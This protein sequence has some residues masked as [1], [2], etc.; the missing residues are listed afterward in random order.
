MTHPIYHAVIMCRHGN[1]VI[2]FGVLSFSSERET[3]RQKEP[4]E[5]KRTTRI[6][7]RI[8]QGEGIR[9]SYCVR[10]KPC[11]PECLPLVRRRNG[12]RKITC[13]SKWYRLVRSNV[14]D[15]VHPIEEM[16]RKIASSTNECETPKSP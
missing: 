5:T 1:E 16:R 7:E 9:R 2:K 8:M 12:G 3:D 6:Q 4:R 11:S 13:H 14:V 10:W 15:T